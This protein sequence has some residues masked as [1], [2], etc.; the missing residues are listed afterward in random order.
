MEKVAK[1]PS[2]E[3]H[4]AYLTARTITFTIIG[5]G[6]L[7]SLVLAL[8]IARSVTTPVQRIREVLDKVA[9]GD[10]RVR[11]GHTGGAELG[12]VARSLDHTLDSLGRVLTLVNDSAT[13]LAGAS[14]S[15][16]GAAEAI[17]D[18]ARTAAGQ[19]DVVVASAGEGASRGATG[20]PAP[21]R[22]G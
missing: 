16:N 21:R 8:L 5:L 1:E 2:A 3:A 9:A 20:A 4:G 12:D 15:L 17:A 22:G 18:N 7:I 19:A 6:L 14:N 11:A 10:L 13:R